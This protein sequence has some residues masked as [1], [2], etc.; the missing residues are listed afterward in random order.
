M[1]TLWSVPA[2]V[3]A[4]YEISSDRSYK[5][6]LTLVGLAQGQYTTDKTLQRHLF[7]TELKVLALL[8]VER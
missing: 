1:V 4:V 5:L 6:P 7:G 3:S 2:S 8:Q